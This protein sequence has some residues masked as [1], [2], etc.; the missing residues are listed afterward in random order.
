MEVDL[1]YAPKTPPELLYHGTPERYVASI[2][3]EGLRK[4][5]PH[6]V[7]LSAT[8]ETAIAVGQRRG[9]TVVL[10]VR[11]GEMNRAGYQFFVS[12]NGVWL[13]DSV[14]AN[15]LIQGACE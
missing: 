2:Y 3:R 4:G 15:F 12:A 5:Q 13:T 6:H 14:P 7:H 11:A 1:Q 9:K 10:T 8:R